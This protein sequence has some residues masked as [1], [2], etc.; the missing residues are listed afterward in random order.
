VSPDAAP[1]RPVIITTASGASESSGS[2]PLIK[3]FVFNRFFP[4]PSQSAAAARFSRRIAASSP[5]CLPPASPHRSC[6][7]CLARSSSCSR[8]RTTPHATSPVPC[9]WCPRHR[10]RARALHLA[11]GEP[12]TAVGLHSSRSS[13]PVQPS[14]LCPS[15]L[16]SPSTTEQSRVLAQTLT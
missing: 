8:P 1:P 14:P 10:S 16:P 13:S 2:E 7:P 6:R 12:S 9:P 11:A 4:L 3:P 15:S 5:S